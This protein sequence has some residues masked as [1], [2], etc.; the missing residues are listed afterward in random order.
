LGR[1]GR[2]RRAALGLGRGGR[3]RRAALGIWTRRPIG[4]SKAALGVIWK[5]RNAA[6]SANCRGSRRTRS[7]FGLGGPSAGAGAALDMIWRERKAV[8]NVI[9]GGRRTIRFGGSR[10]AAL[11]RRDHR[12]EQ[13]ERRGGAT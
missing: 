7:T 8:H 13:A 9:C 5:Q 2:S 4:R 1:G 10:R 3:S 6:L 11:G 12:Q